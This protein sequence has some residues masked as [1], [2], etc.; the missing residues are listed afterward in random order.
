MGP[1]TALA[2]L[3]NLDNDPRRLRTSRAAGAWVGLRPKRR[4]SGGREPELS[5]TKSGDPLPRR[6]LVQ[7][8]QYVLGPFGEDSEL[9]RWG[10]RLAARGGKAAKRK[11]VVAVARKLAVILHVLWLREVDF[12]PFP[13]G[14]SEAAPSA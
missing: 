9:R 10:L 11:A 14:R 13:H 1:T 2:Y 5:V 6:L 3:L 8:A 12:E 7:C 4:N